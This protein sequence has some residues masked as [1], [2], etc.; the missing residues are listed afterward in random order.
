MIRSENARVSFLDS[1]GQTVQM[2]DLYGL[3]TDTKPTTGLAN[4]S[5]FV[6]VD[7]GKLFLFNEDTGEWSEISTGGGGAENYKETLTGT[8]ATLAADLNAVYDS[9]EKVYALCEEML[10]GNANME[11]T[12][13]ASALEQSVVTM[14][15]SALSDTQLYAGQSGWSWTSETA[16]LGSVV[17][18]N[19]DLQSDGLELNA[20]YLY[21]EGTVT[22]LSPYASALPY[23][24]KI[25][26]HPMPTN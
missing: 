24:L 20:L 22:N 21:L 26:H 14:P 17:L 15:M 13:D 19:L 11:I 12:V 9:Y 10:A 8:L 7:T 23:E 6:E 2:S 4:G 25:F 5:M 16:T 18:I 1:N 3:S